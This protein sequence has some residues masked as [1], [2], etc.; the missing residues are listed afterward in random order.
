MTDTLVSA[1][2]F[3]EDRDHINLGNQIDFFLVFSSLA[4]SATET[5]RLLYNVSSLL[6]GKNRKSRIFLNHHANMYFDTGSLKD[7]LDNKKE[8]SNKALLVAKNV[9]LHISILNCLSHTVL[10]P[11]AE[12]LLEQYKHSVFNIQERDLK[13]RNK[14]NDHNSN[15]DYIAQANLQ[16]KMQQKYYLDFVVPLLHDWLSESESS[17]ISF[18]K[19]HLNKAKIADTKQLNKHFFK[20]TGLHFVEILSNLRFYNTTGDTHNRAIN[21]IMSQV[22]GDLNTLAFHLQKLFVE[23]EPKSLSSSEKALMY[24]LVSQMIILSNSQIPSNAWKIAKA[25]AKFSGVIP[26]KTNMSESAS[27]YIAYVSAHVVRIMIA[28]TLS[29]SNMDILFKFFSELSIEAED[30]ILHLWQIDQQLMLQDKK[31]IARH[32]FLYFLNKSSSLEETHQNNTNHRPSIHGLAAA[33]RFLNLS[34]LSDKEKIYYGKHFEQILQSYSTDILDSVSIGDGMN[35]KYYKYNDKN[36]HFSSSL[37]KNVFDKNKDLLDFYFLGNLNSQSLNALMPLISALCIFLTYIKF[38]T[39]SSPKKSISKKIR[40]RQLIPNDDKN[41]ETTPQIDYSQL[42]QKHK[43]TKE[44][45]KHVIG[46]VEKL[47]EPSNSDTLSAITL[48]DINSV[49]E[50]IDKTNSVG[51]VSI[52]EVEVALLRLTSEYKKYKDNQEHKKN[53]ISYS[54]KRSALHSLTVFK[55]K[56]DDDIKQYLTS[57]EGEL[58]LKSKEYERSI[59]KLR[60]EKSRCSREKNTPAKELSSHILKLEQQIGLHQSEKEHLSY[61]LNKIGYLIQLTKTYEGSLPEGLNS[62]ISNDFI[63]SVNDTLSPQSR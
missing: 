11:V 60:R 12:K 22:N 49:R 50:I 32:V 36:N 26:N 37:I 3:G 54:T 40:K 48:D 46:E 55:G 13:I 15:I 43:I 25:S 9:T 44:S 45:L 31:D 19:R 16:L 61:M 62:C 59:V 14:L 52:D 21:A 38:S 20:F 53:I 8:N 29:Y 33:L 6:T 41:N 27:H 1:I 57:K 24:D 4:T 51:H 17:D 10:I 28:N 34:G 63:R 35:V 18:F 7:L 56:S 5:Y 58:S 39:Y 23:R 30:V 47:K 42:L 2:T